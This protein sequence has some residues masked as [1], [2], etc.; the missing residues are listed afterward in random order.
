MTYKN[1]NAEASAGRIDL[2]LEI[3]VELLFYL[4]DLAAAYQLR[5]GSCSRPP[6]RPTGRARR[7]LEGK[8]DE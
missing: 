3:D 1:K 4:E 7:N 6:S 8:R 2:A 5:S